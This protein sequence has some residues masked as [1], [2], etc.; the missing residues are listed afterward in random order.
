MESIGKLLSTTKVLEELYLS[1]NKIRGVGALCIVQ[2]IRKQ[3]SLR[4][5]DLS[6]NSLASSDNRAV[7]IAL[8]DSVSNNHILEHFDISNNQFDVEDMG[9]LAK[10]MIG[11]HTL[12]GLHV[13]GNQGSVDAKGFIVPDSSGVQ[14]QS[15]H[16]FCSIYKFEISEDNFPAHLWPYAERSCWYCGGWSEFQFTW[17]PAAVNVEIKPGEKVYLNLSID[18]WK[19][20][21][22][23][24]MD[25]KSY[26]LYRV[27]PP[28]KTQYFISVINP[29][30]PTTQTRRFMRKDKHSSRLLRR[31]G[32]AITFGHLQRAN[33]IEMPRTESRYPC[34]S[35]FPRRDEKNSMKKRKWEL[36]KSQFAPRLR[37]SQS[38]SFTHGEGFYA[39]A[40]AADWKLCKADRVV[41]NTD[42]RQSLENVCLKYFPKIV[43]I[44]QKYCGKS[45]VLK[46][47]ANSGPPDVASISWNGFVEFLNDC[48]LID[49]KCHMSAMEN[50]FLAANLEVTTEAKELD[51]PDR[52]LTRF[53]FL[54]CIF[55]IAIAKNTGKSDGSLAQ[56]MEMLMKE[57]ILPHCDTETDEF[58]LE[59]IYHEEMDE[60]LTENVVM[61][62][63]YRQS[64]TR[65][66]HFQL[67]DIYDT[68]MGR[69]CK[70]GDRKGMSILEA[71]ELL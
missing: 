56:A 41:K 18:D 21:A 29:N 8:A 27:L 23:I 12:I 67:R 57:S 20:D 45:I 47:S 30:D 63:R 58:R 59:Y 13:S 39:K 4:V 40:F 34:D 17:T 48:A 52:S 5:L 2:A 22:M 3:P 60:L 55:R 62:R 65:L 32:D 19:G 11:N 42:Q 26:V 66:T 50:I 43:R 15:Q 37:E 54:E 33:Y 51:N 9:V 38:R 46:K 49:D 69:N 53:E 24:Q 31:P 71:L 68:H 61:V 36:K 14:I 7:V 70:A 1:W 6:W 28:G 35:T 25:D 10:G 16:K 44:Y 64:A